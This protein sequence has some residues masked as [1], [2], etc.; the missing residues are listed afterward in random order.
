MGCRVSIKRTAICREGIL[1]EQKYLLVNVENNV[2]VVT[3]HRPEALNAL[4]SA[5][6]EELDQVV[7]AL[8]ADP[9]VRVIVFTGEGKS[10]IAGADLD[11]LGNARGF[12]VMEYSRRGRD[13]FRKIELLP[14]A[15]IA[16]VNGYAFGG[17]FEF[18]LCCDIRIA[19]EKA[20][21]A[22]PEVTFGITPGFN[23]TKRLP[24]EIGLAKAKELL[25]TGRRIKV[26]EALELG[27]LNQV[28]DMEGFWPAVMAMADQIAD[29]SATSVELIKMAVTSGMDAGF[30][31][32][33]EVE[34]G[35][36]AA[37]FGTRDQ[38][39]GYAAFKQKRKPIYR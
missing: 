38:I 22:M 5:V 35:Y 1:M 30:D 19:C 6:L 20:S 17:G 39:E 3:F 25:F 36:M 8:A 11:E 10:F 2:A 13:L 21:L 34:M 15:T 16:A 9:A 32:A 12:E 23:G 24:R 4:N 28:T 14:K 37:A 29:N 18:L 26:E 33:K 7:D 31:V 27:V